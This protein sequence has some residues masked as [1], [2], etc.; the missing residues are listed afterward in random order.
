MEDH[1]IMRRDLVERIG[2]IEKEFPGIHERLKTRKKR[3]RIPILLGYSIR[4]LTT[5]FPTDVV[6]VKTDER[7]VVAAMWC[8]RMFHAEEG[9]IEQSNWIEI[10]SRLGEPA[11]IKTYETERV[12]IIHRTNAHFDRDNLLQYQSY[13]C[14]N[15]LEEGIVEVAW[16]DGKEG[17]GPTYKIDLNR[18]GIKKQRF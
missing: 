13:V 7:Q 2:T 15:L 1:D 18:P 10:Y 12:C 11:E 17:K 16:S 3:E 4:K 5:D 6:Y 9:G 14:L 8:R